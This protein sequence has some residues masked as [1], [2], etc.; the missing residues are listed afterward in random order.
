[1]KIQN[2][3]DNNKFTGGKVFIDGLNSRQQKTVSKV[4]PFLN[5]Q[6]SGQ[7]FN[8]YISGSLS[9]DKKVI[10]RA[11]NKSPKYIHLITQRKPATVPTACEVTNVCHP[12][13]LIGKIKQVIAEH[14]KYVKTLVKK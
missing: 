5:N 13:V 2:L 4:R 11:Y 3:S 1:M 12:D 7:N 6:L 8:L 14:H 10:S 9:A